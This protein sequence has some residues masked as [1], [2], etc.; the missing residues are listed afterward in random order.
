MGGRDQFSL[1]LR[2][3]GQQSLLRSSRRNGHA[4]LLLTRL[5]LVPTDPPF[6][7]PEAPRPLYTVRTYTRLAG[8]ADYD[9]GPSCPDRLRSFESAT[10]P[11]K[12]KMATLPHT[13]SRR[14]RYQRHARD[15]QRTAYVQGVRNYL[16]FA[17]RRFYP[18]NA[19]ER[20][21]HYVRLQ[22]TVYNRATVTTD[23]RHVT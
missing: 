16:Q 5:G 12:G 15:A 9:S 14:S 7:E 18:P 23:D 21:P 4:R 17:R 22:A 2:R 10:W 1:P 3:F 11:A 8:N 19:N 20:A 13:R 6:G